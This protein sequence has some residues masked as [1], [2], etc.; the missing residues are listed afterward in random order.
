MASLTPEQ[1]RRLLSA[2]SLT[3]EHVSMTPE[4]RAFL[5]QPHRMGHVALEQSTHQSPSAQAPHA[6]STGPKAPQYVPLQAD[7]EIRVL[8]VK[9][10]TGSQRLRCS[11]ER[12]P[13]IGD[14][15]YEALSYTW[16]AP[17]R[18]RYYD[19]NLAGNRHERSPE[20]YLAALIGGYVWSASNGNARPDTQLEDFDESAL[21]EPQKVMIDGVKC[22]VTGNLA[23]ALLQL[24]VPSEDRVL[25]V[26]AVCINQ[27]DIQEKS[28]QVSF[29]DTIYQRCE[30]VRIWLGPAADGSDVAMQLIELL[31]AWKCECTDGVSMLTDSPTPEML[32]TIED[33]TILL[34]RPW[35]TRRWTVQELAFASKAVV[36]CGARSVEW[37]KMAYAISF[38]RD[39]RLEINYLRIKNLHMAVS[40]TL[41][42]RG[43][44]QTLAA[45][46]SLFVC[47]K[48]IRA[49]PVPGQQV[50]RLADIE[51]LV[52]GLH[53]LQVSAEY[54][55][56]TIYALLSLA[57]DT[58]NAPDRWYTDYAKPASDLFI[59]FVEWAIEMSGSLN[60]ICRP[61]APSGEGLTLPTWIQRHHPSATR[62]E[63]GGDREQGRESLVGLG[64]KTRFNASKNIPAAAEMVDVEGLGKTLGVYGFKVDEIVEVSPVAHLGLP[65]AWK[66]L[67]LSQKFTLPEHT[68]A[69]VPEEGA[70]N[71][72]IKK[73][74]RKFHRKHDR[75]SRSIATNVEEKDTRQ[76]SYANLADILVAGQAGVDRLTRALRGQMCEALFADTSP[77]RHNEEVIDILEV[78]G[79]ASP[80]PLYPPDSETPFP[81]QYLHE[82]LRRIESCTRNRALARTSSGK[83]ALVDHLV[84]PGDHMCILFGCDVPVVLRPRPAL[85]AGVQAAAVSLF[86]FRGEAYVPGIMEG[87]AVSAMQEAER[88]EAPTTTRYLLR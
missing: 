58:T 28:E 4:T 79:E 75:G 47:E 24:R 11:L 74:W 40:P 21:A 76:E 44:L 48:I 80:A 46:T 36:H 49:N 86:D 29:M 54:P 23:S 83:L 12:R 35:F 42:R 82:F 45:E 55:H 59:E 81:T 66:D 63:G 37:Q 9:K 26:D 16:G 22:D 10:G 15:P 20:S 25:W 72:G 41:Y 1:I 65:V 43:Y 52:C 8:I 30:T 32:S 62:H 51:T 67:V 56:D 34:M 19:K 14:L 84:E 64:K 71:G 7:R 60:V 3:V 68:P 39:H 61:W 33:L 27:S 5:S 50:E 13:L 31:W 57:N 17:M 53:A 38:L 85:D 70:E 77:Y 18:T 73:M 69:I 2:G 88:H 6:S 87:Q 78:R